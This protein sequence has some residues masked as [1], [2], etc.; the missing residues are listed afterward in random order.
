[1]DPAMAGNDDAGVQRIDQIQRLQQHLRLPVDHHRDAILEQDVPREEHPLLRQPE[2]DPVLSLA[3][4]LRGDHDE[5]R[6]PEL[7]LVVAA[8]I[9]LA[10][11]ANLPIPNIFRPPIAKACS[12]FAD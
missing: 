8:R 4:I 6:P 12:G 7:E 11:R 5:F 2:E 3:G 9:D 10:L 1:M